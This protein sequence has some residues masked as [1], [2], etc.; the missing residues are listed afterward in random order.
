MLVILMSSKLSLL[1]SNIWWQVCTLLAENARLG[2]GRAGEALI[3]TDRKSNICE[4][5]GYLLTSAN[6]RGRLS[7]TSFNLHEQ[8][9]EF[10]QIS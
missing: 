6:N 3:R 1:L 10:T 8:I 9:V 4:Y 5:R 2:P 7:M